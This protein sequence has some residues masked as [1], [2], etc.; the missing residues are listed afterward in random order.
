MKK[1][2]KSV[3]SVLL[4]LVLVL[5]LAACGQQE[6]SSEEGTETEDTQEKYKIGVCFPTAMNEF[7]QY[8][9]EMMTEAA[10]ER[11]DVE[12]LLQVADDDADTQFSQVENLI[13]QGID[14][15]IICAVDVSAIGPALDACHDAGIHVIALRRIPQDCYVDAVSLFDQYQKG[16]QSALAALEAAPE[17]NYALLNADISSLPDEVEFEEGWYDALQ[18]AIDAGDIEIV[19][20]QNCVNWT[21]DQGLMHTESALSLTNNDLAAV[22]CANDD[23]AAGAISALEQAGL[24]GDVVVTGADANLS[25][26]QYILEGKQYS[27]IW[28]DSKTQHEACLDMAVKL[29][30]GQDLGEADISYNNG[31]M[32]I[33]AYRLDIDFIT[34]EDDMINTVIADGRYTEEEVFGE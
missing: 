25:A 23:I 24:D 3:L 9:Q 26:L 14:A 34:T 13:T 27:T 20:E 33:P 28:Q 18:D 15:L 8:D 11:D 22:I 32:D 6:T 7:W 31:E 30:E 29:I 16:Y 12:I 2:T 4:A 17:G 21:S 5:G 10:A 19:L 1:A